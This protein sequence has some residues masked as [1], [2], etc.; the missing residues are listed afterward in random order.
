MTYY[1][2]EGIKDACNTCTQTRSSPHTTTR[3]NRMPVALIGYGSRLTAWNPAQVAAFKPNQTKARLRHLG[4]IETPIPR[5]ICVG[6]WFDSK[7]LKPEM[8]EAQK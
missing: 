8:V 4:K 3:I 5:G 7:P 1:N 6:P 2:E